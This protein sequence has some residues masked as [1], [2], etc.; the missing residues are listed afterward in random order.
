[1]SETVLNIIYIALP[2]SLMFSWVFFLYFFIQKKHHQD[3][4][5]KLL[6][7]SR[8]LINKLKD[9]LTDS[10]KL[11]K[12]YA[13]N[14]EE[15]A[16]VAIDIIDNALKKEIPLDAL[17]ELNTS[18]ATLINQ[19]DALSDSSGNDDKEKKQLK[20]HV[21]TLKAQAQTTETILERLKSEAEANRYKLE[22][23]EEKLHKQRLELDKIEGLED[24]ERKA[25]IRNRTLIKKVKEQNTQLEVYK[26]LETKVESLQKIKNHLDLK[27]S[28]QTHELEKQ[29]RV[30]AK[31]KQ[32]ISIDETA[33]FL[34]I[35]Q[36]TKDICSEN[37]G[38]ID[39]LQEQLSLLNL[40]LSESTSA[41]ERANREKDFIET[42]F[43]D[44]IESIDK[45]DDVKSE[46]VRVKKEYSMLE[47]HFI[48]IQEELDT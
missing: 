35:E 10:R 18:Q 17:T 1:M 45:K 21:A 5:L 12:Q 37:E 15:T 9:D 27:I 3:K 47:D 41:L 24:K 20:I 34:P 23:L 25:R 11:I 32:K 42:Q 29:Q 14:A 6:A 28:Q 7:R 2:I 22:Y 31:L 46:L 8:S 40:Q 19:L 13:N 36:E 44:L 48:R 33:T 30:I 43:L 26:T 4:L 38:Q 16:N 39:Q